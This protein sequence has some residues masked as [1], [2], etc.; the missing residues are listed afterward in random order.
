[1]L[2]RMTRERF[3]S[4]AELAAFLRAVRERRHKNQPRD[5]AL[6]VLLA[7]TG[8]RPSEALALTRADVRLGQEPTIQLHRVSKRHSPAPTNQIPLHPAVADIVARH[9]EGL[10]EG[11]NL[12]PFT[13]RQAARI[14]HTYAKVA[15]LSFSYRIY[16]LRHTA[17]MRLYRF[18]RDLRFVQGLMG[19][20]QVAATMAYVHIAPDVL[21]GAYQA[22]ESAG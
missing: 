9:C 1:M 8:I 16:C 7:N 4:D 6:F 13:K 21:R 2:R 15:G 22:A 11:A 10:P 12:F 17:G 19:H 20:S 18:T 14:F 3:L 5:Y